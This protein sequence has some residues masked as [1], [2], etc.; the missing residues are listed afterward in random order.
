MSDLTN[1]L[2]S[3][4]PEYE[5][6]DSDMG[7]FV[8]DL[9][10]RGIRITNDRIR[11]PSGKTM[12]Q[13]AISFSGFSS[14]GDGL[15]FD[16]TIDWDVFCKTHQKMAEDITEWFLLL[17]TNPDLITAG[18]SRDRRYYSMTFQ[19]DYNAAYGDTVEHGFFAGV[20][21]QDLPVIDSKLDS[22]MSEE[23][24]DE[25]DTM[26]RILEKTYDAECEFM[27]E[28]EIENIKDEHADALAEAMRVLP[29]VVTRRVADEILSGFTEIDFADLDELGLYV[30]FGGVY[31]KKEVICEVSV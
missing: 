29:D 23:L 28:Q 16:C 20:D 14:Q 24:E 27:R 8:E 2:G 31:L 30:F 19:M 25:A 3:L 17:S 15:A 4:Y 12:E 26:Y 11:Y 1:G 9:A 5:W 21:T 22:W 18:T 6:W 13:P 10:A 7:F